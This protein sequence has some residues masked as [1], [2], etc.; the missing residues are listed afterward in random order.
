M[1]LVQEMVKAYKYLFTQSL[2]ITI[3]LLI[4]I[5][6]L[7]KKQKELNDNEIEQYKSFKLSNE[8]R[9]S[10]DELTHYCRTYVLTGDSIWEEK[11]QDLLDARDD[12]MIIP[13]NEEINLI[14]NFS[15]LNFSKEEIE[16]FNLAKKNSQDLVEVELEA[17]KLVKNISDSNKYSDLNKA[18]RI[19]FDE[20]YSSAKENIRNLINDFNRKVDSRIMINIIK[21]K[22]QVEVLTYILM[23][24]IVTL[25]ASLIFFL[26]LIQNKVKEQKQHE[27][28]LKEAKKEAEESDKFKSIFLAN[29]SH[30]F[31]TPLNAI[32][33]FGTQLKSFYK[34]DPI[35]QK[36]IRIVG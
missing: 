3:F 30:E 11:Y 6:L 35:Y 18:K 36:Y 14:N 34:D 5:V 27:R 17:F 21:A 20:N 26:V 25:I 1:I 33:G 7:N 15:A 24:L 16:V 23:I 12:N 22:N 9:N 10:S 4:I 29:M 28:D 32:I 8:L 13:S 31:R 19:I 2:I